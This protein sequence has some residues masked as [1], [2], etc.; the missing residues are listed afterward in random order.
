M[1]TNPNPQSGWKE[2]RRYYDHLDKPVVLQEYVKSGSPVNRSNQLAIQVYSTVAIN[3]DYYWLLRNFL[4]GKHHDEH[5]LPLLEI[6]GYPPADAFD[7]AEHNRRE[8]AHRKRQYRTLRSTDLPPLIPITHH[9]ATGAQ[10][11]A[12]VLINSHS[13][14]LGHVIDEMTFQRQPAPD[15]IY[16][17]R[18]FAHSFLQVTN[19]SRVSGFFKTVNEKCEDIL[20]PEGFELDVRRPRDKDQ[21]VELVT[22]IF[23]RRFG[24]QQKHYPHIHF[25]FDEDEGEIPT[26]PP[27]QEPNR[28]IKL[29]LNR[30][31]AG[32]MLPLSKLA[33][34]SKEIEYPTVSIWIT[35]DKT[36]VDKDLQYLVSVPFLSHIPCATGLLEKTAK[37]FTALLMSH[38]P[39][40]KSAHLIFYVPLASGI[41]TNLPHNHG[42][43][44]NIL[45]AHRRT[46]RSIRC[47]SHG[48]ATGALH[49]SDSIGIE[50]RDLMNYRLLP[51]QRE[52]KPDTPK[53]SALRTY[54]IFSIV[55][56][57]SKFVENEGIHLF[58][59]DYDQ[60]DLPPDDFSPSSQ[61]LRCTGMAMLTRRLSMAVVDDQKA[62]NKG[63]Y[64]D[65]GDERGSN[66]G[67]DGDGDRPR[68]DYGGDA[69]Q[70]VGDVAL[71]N[72]MLPK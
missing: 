27:E 48:F 18:K 64:G 9:P 37:L 38:L 31:I 60:I 30:Q 26:T 21:L 56:T 70:W 15:I 55:L 33:H 52:D 53:A 51:Q 8:I 4:L 7:C 72:G 35:R 57:T 67:G 58:M 54:E 32:V 71:V 17:N 69:G 12:C 3:P 5:D 59:T 10:V 62:T 45:H 39:P 24:L 13:Y 29:N 63:Y 40:R 47:D 11:G 61:I 16:F 20:H 1:P 14:R 46:L 34:W 36:G 23:K 66:G 19:D 50:P 49:G 2:Q 28:K 68:G 43:W 44:S 22:D 41:W 6:Y 65:G 25:A 42:M